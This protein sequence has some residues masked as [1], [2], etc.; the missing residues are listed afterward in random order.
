MTWLRRLRRLAS[1]RRRRTADRSIRKALGGTT[2]PSY[3]TDYVSSFGEDWTRALSPMAGR[4][5]VRMLEIG[6]F[7]GR[8]AVWFLKHVLTD[9]SSELICVDVFSRPGLEARFDHNIRLA[10]PHGQVRKLKG[11]SADVLANLDAASFDAIYVDGGHDAAT[12]LLDAVLAWKLL[13]P[14]GILI[15]DDYLWELERPLSERPQLAVDLF[16]ESMGDALEILH[17]GYQVIGRKADRRAP[18]SS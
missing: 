12:V 17:A 5:G 6:S 11:K 18:L 8:S 4:P 3:T 10:D 7:E 2:E 15:F 9:E 14:G 1:E 16:R 13:K